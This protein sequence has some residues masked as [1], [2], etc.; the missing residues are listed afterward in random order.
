MATLSFFP[1]SQIKFSANYD[2][3]D[4]NGKNVNVE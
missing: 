4:Y 2:N 3:T 1:P